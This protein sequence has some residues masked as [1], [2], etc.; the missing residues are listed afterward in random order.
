MP[1][2]EDEDV[3][4]SE[5]KITLKK[6]SAQKSIFD[7]LPKRQSPE[8]F[9]KRV[10]KIQ[11][12]IEGFKLKASEL[13]L[14]FSK[15]M[16]D[17]TLKNNKTIFSVEIERELLSNMIKLAVE[18]NEDSCQEHDGM[19][20]LSWITLLLK[21]SFNQRDKINNLEYIVAQLEKKIESLDTKKTVNIL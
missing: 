6:V 11:E 2:D 18:I 20:S 8:E 3:Q 10:H 14:Q 17:K 7:S 5:K 9:D 19:G 12:K 4:S 1:F 15:M 13:A 21:N 16:A